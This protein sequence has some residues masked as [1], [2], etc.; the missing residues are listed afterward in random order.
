M[1]VVNLFIDGDQWCAMGGVDLVD[2]PCGF[3]LAPADALRSL[4]DAIELYG[5]Y[6][7]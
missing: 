1:G 5:W 2:G 4:A 6:C 7:G 3:G